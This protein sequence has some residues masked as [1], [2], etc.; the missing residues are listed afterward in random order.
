MNQQLF[1]YYRVANANLEAVLACTRQFGK[2]LQAQ[3][4]GRLTMFQRE[5]AGKPYITLMEVIYPDSA[6]SHGLET[7]MATIKRMAED[8]FSSISPT[9]ERHVE[10]FVALP[11][12]GAP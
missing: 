3:G 10:V 1:I 2:N 9:P 7:F 12:D 5:E 11:G 6:Y 8:S 4:L